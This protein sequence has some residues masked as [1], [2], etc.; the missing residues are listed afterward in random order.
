MKE[1]T[2]D[3]RIRKTKQQLRQSLTALLKE[4]RI[5]NITVRELAELADINRGTFYLHY[6]DAFDLLRQIEDELLDELET[7]LAKYQPGEIR[8]NGVRIFTDIYQLAQKNS[9]LVTILLGEHG[10][11]N[12][13]TRP[14]KILRDKCLHDWLEYFRTEDRQE[15]DH[16]YVFIV[17]GCIGLLQ[18]WLNHNMKETP[19]ELASLTEQIILNGVKL[20][21]ARE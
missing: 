15:F 6:K 19:E 13:V 4:K 8:Q 18:Y 16:Y 9:E 1:G 5:E 17:S 3:R 10:E 20:M 21:D 11:L 2:I 7:V 12:F 14:N